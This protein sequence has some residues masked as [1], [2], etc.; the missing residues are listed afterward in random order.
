MTAY[1]PPTP[2]TWSA[3][4][5]PTATLLNG[6]VRDPQTWML[7]LPA[8]YGEKNS[9]PLAIPNSTWTAIPLDV[10]DIKRGFT[11]TLGSS[12]VYV[13]QA[14]WYRLTANALLA[15]TTTGK[16]GGHQIGFYMNGNTW[17]G[18]GAQLGPAGETAGY[19]SSG[20]RNVFY[21]LTAGAFVQMMVFQ[22]GG[23]STDCTT[24]PGL[25]STNFSMIW[26]GRDAT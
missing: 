13:D 15:H 25:T 7:G 26:Q 5:I 8:Y 20:S 1:P 4:E 19:F 22:N 10:D 11:H 12:I 16:V 24:Y 21:Y 9:T 18:G 3:Q 14:G 23:S 17:L 2:Y 6:N